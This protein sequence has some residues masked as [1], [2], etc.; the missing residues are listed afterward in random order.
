MLFRLFVL[1]KGTIASTTWMSVEHFSRLQLLLLAPLFC[2]SFAWAWPPTYGA[3]FEF[4]NH[5]LQQGEDKP[6]RLKGNEKEGAYLFG[7]ALMFHCKVFACKIRPVPGKWGTDYRVELK[8]G[9]WFQISYDPRVVEILTKPSTLS[10]WKENARL[11]NDLVFKT[12]K[13]LGFEVEPKKRGGHFSF[14]IA[15]TFDGSADLFLRYFNDFAN[16]PELALGIFRKNLYNA[17]PLALLGEGPL[18]A[19][20]KLNQDFLKNP[21]MSLEEVIQRIETTV[22]TK[23]YYDGLD[24]LHYQA[25]AIKEPHIPQRARLEIR[26]MRSQRSAEEFILLAE[27]LEARIKY[28]K[29]LPSEKTLRVEKNLRTE[30]TDQE[31]VE[32]FRQYLSEAGLSWEKYSV[33]LPEELRRFLP[34]TTGQFAPMCPRVHR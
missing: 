12:A 13:D 6:A 17:P 30:F 14:G 8:S 26:A 34:K 25:L 19:L 2:A 33:M 18:E 1:F 20:H 9:F 15:S 16:H 27:I 4:T 3:E 7:K 32:R 29:S 22:Y 28:L 24:A 23:S 5:W 21:K 11:V 10:E 31:L